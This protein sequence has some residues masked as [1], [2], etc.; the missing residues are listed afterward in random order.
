MNA[1]LYDL[2][3]YAKKRN[4]QLLNREFSSTKKAMCM[5]FD[6]NEVIILDLNKIN[7]EAEELCLLAEELGH[8]QTESLYTMSQICNAKFN[9]SI[10]DSEY[11]AEY[12]MI[13]KLIPIN[14]LHNT[15]KSGLYEI[16]ELAEYLELPGDLI[17]KAIRYYKIEAC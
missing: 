5:K 3:H 4:I 13:E 17:E 7:S 16:S 1:T 14:E 10:K 8:L 9:N 12:W 6:D 15:I 2:Y 11:R